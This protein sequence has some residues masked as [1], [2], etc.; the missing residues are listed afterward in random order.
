MLIARSGWK[1]TRNVD[2]GRRVEV[3]DGMIVG[4][5]G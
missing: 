4:Y 2:W 1:E 5:G 3:G